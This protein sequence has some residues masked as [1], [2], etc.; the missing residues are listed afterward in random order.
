[1]DGIDTYDMSF[2]RRP[3]S[4]LV[5]WKIGMVNCRGGYRR[6]SQNQ[7]PDAVPVIPDLPFPA[8]AGNPESHWVLEVI[9]GI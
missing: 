4:I 9:V 3:E 7:R 5:Q 1:M 8:Q 6:L 2:R